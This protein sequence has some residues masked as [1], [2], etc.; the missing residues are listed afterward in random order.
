MM[1]KF[2][3][4]IIPLLLFLLCFFSGP[5]QITREAARTRLEVM[6]DSAL[7]FC[8]AKGMNTAFCVLVDMKEHSG[9][10]RFHVWDFGKGEATLSSLCCHGQGQGSTGAQPVFSN[11][12]GSYCTSL[13]RYRIGARAPSQWGIKIHY[14]LHGLDPTNNNA[15]KRIVVLHSFAPV[16][17]SEIYPVHLPLGMSLGCPVISDDAMRTMDDKLQKVEKPVLLWIF[18]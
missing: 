5:A 12:E 17:G 14:K 11:V 7:I 6:A 15:Y 10:Y 4:Y 3:F 2:V 8:K 1:K 13:G 9:R 16:P 18:Y